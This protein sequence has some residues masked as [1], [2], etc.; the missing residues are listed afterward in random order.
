MADLSRFQAGGEIPINGFLAEVTNGE[1]LII[2][3]KGREFLLSGIV[4]TDVA[5]YPDAKQSPAFI[6]TNELPRISVGGSIGA[7]PI[8]ITFEKNG[9]FYLLDTS[10]VG[11]TFDSSG[12]LI[13]SVDISASLQTAALFGT[14]G[15]NGNF[16]IITTA[17][18]V[19]EITDAWVVVN[20]YDVSAVVDTNLASLA[21]RSSN[22]TFWIAASN[23][24]DI[25]EFS[26]DFTTNTVIATN[27][28]SS[29]GQFVGDIFVY[30]IS[31]T[32][33][34]TFRYISGAILPSPSSGIIDISTATATYSEVTQNLCG[35]DN[36]I[37]RIIRVPVTK[38]IGWAGSQALS[39]SSGLRLYVRIK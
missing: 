19:Y 38:Y 26:S 17:K 37:D 25:K 22:D 2:D 33:A 10:G 24:S 15:G 7:T 29:D 5:S 3:D 39:S 9:N 16:Y 21:Y 30:T 12:N 8:I 36:N 4:E 18:I 20:S 13:T 27:V 34:P 14:H 32:M 6:G 31:T 11:F 1:A 28:S 23:P 35:F